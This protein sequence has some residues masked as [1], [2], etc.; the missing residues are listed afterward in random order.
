MS[1]RVARGRLESL[2]GGLAVAAALAGAFLS[3][4]AY[5]LYAYSARA[6]ALSPVL[7]TWHASVLA[8]QARI[9]AERRAG[10]AA[11]HSLTASLGALS[12]HILRLD[13]QAQGLVEDR[14]LDL[15]DFDFGRDPALG[16]PEEPAVETEVQ[17]GDL[18]ASLASLAG[19]VDNRA[20]Q[21][22]AL[23]GV[24]EWRS[25]RAAIRPTGP[26]IA[27]GYVSSGFGARIDPFTGKRTA[28]YGVDFAARRGTPVVAVAAGVVTWA[29]PRGGYGKLVE[30]D[31]GHGRVTRY[32][33]NSKILVHVGQLVARGQ[34]IA[35]LGAT[36]RATGPNLHFEVRQNGRAVDPSPFLKG[37]P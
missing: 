30:L 32:G 29:G 27:G 25:L 14:K 10:Q 2:L 28:H 13:A 6:A 22:D 7:E 34:L 15:P 5:R 23:M 35:R 24:L 4:Q 37:R 17:A 26:P 1:G 31:H 36:G 21:L 12:G 18:E 33:H 3:V 11:L 20:R 16:G 19:T 9:A 8:D